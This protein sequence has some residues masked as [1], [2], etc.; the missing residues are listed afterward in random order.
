MSTTDCTDSNASSLGRAGDT[1]EPLYHVTVLSNFA[2]GYDKYGRVYDKAR[3]VE[4]TY[5]DRFFLLSRHEIGIGVAKAS[6]LLRKTGLA[7]D[8][9]VAI[10][11]R[12]DPGDLH[13][14]VRTGRGRFV[15]RSFVH[16]DAVHFVDDAGC[17][18]G[19]RI[20]EAIALS[21][22]L[23]APVRAAYEQ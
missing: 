18:T 20:E 5:P 11:T 3:I 7:G 9:L 15:E 6:A 23:H 21:L 16:V 1:T 12:A 14:N 2:R 22:R 19:V 17:L 13:P 10:Q 4:S 8:R